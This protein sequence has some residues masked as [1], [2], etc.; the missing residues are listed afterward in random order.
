MAYRG[1]HPLGSRLLLGVRCLNGSGTP[2]L[3]DNAPVALVYSSTGLVASLRLPVVDRQDVTGWFAQPLL[4][5]SRFAAGPHRVV[6]QYSLS[7]TAGGQSD[8]FEVVPGGHADGAG[9]A[10][11]YY[12]RP[13][14]DFVLL[15]TDSGR[16]LRRRNP[17]V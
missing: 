8:H 17:R 3:P 12:S 15:Q 13:A 16:L 9:L 7:G 4:L 11:S 14:S 6:Y 10:V 1:R 2:T 5:D